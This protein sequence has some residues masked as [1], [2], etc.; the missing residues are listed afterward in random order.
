[1]WRAVV[2]FLCLAAVGYGASWLADRPG[3]IS[4]QWLGLRVETSVGVL[5]A[6]LLVL[7][8]VVVTV[9]KVW[10][11]IRDAPEALRRNRVTNKQRRGYDALTKGLVAIAAG[12]AKEARRLSDRAGNLL[13]EPP[14]TLL[15]SA[16]VASLEGDESGA[17]KRF[18]E[19]A[20]HPETE[21]LGVR[22]LLVQAKR[23]GDTK[24]ALALAERAFQLRPDATWVVSEL[25]SLQAQQEDWSAAQTTLSHGL[26]RKLLPESEAQRNRAVVAYGQAMSAEARG[27]HKMALD[28]AKQSHKYDPD[29]IP[30]TALAARMMTT[31]GQMR[32]ARKL[33]EEAWGHAP[34]PE[35]AA[36][37]ADMHPDESAEARRERLRKLAA[38]KPD[39][40]ESFIM[41]AQAAMAC[42]DWDDAR[43]QL[44]AIETPNPDARF[45]R[46]MA[47]LTERS[48]GDM[49]QARDWLRRAANA[50][51]HAAWVCGDCGRQ[52]LTWAPHCPECHAFDSFRW[53]APH[54]A[55]PA[56]LSELSAMSEEDTEPEPAPAPAEEEAKPAA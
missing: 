36:A 21:F 46:L 35:L 31:L 50:R 39:H 43:K 12:D 49:A 47:D 8:A 2:L 7:L 32:R 13:D 53:K 23:A 52:V 55:P 30:A 40:E 20:E 48:G 42:S 5:A 14:L 56:L 25:F 29:F 27:E 41:L 51:F 26:K 34:H 28:H 9:Y 11:W 15:L 37:Y 1:M 33:L 38:L 24:A 54:I 44:E 19:L 6:A 17:R 10:A 3:A 18:Q 4:L 45:C 22:G 16:Q